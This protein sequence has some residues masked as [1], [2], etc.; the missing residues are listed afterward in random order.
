MEIRRAED[1]DG[2][3]CKS[4]SLFDGALA[5]WLVP[6]HK[7]YQRAKLQPIGHSCGIVGV[8]DHELQNDHALP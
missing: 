5:S 1:V 7:I 3:V 8:Q 4:A 2:T 6:H